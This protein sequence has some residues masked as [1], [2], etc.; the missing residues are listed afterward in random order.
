MPPKR[1]V[2]EF[3]QSRRARLQPDEV[4]VPSTGEG[5]RVPGLRRSELAQLAG[6]SVEYYTRLEQGRA[7]NVSAMVLDAI[8][9]ALRLDDTE[10][11]HL[12]DLVRPVPT[13]RPRRSPKQRVRP[14]VH[15]VLDSVT[16]PAFVLGRRMDVLAANRMARL[17]LADF[18]AMEPARRN[19][20]RWI[21]LEPEVR[22]LYVDW[23]T[24]AKETVAILRFD[25]GRHP[26]DPQLSDLVGELSMKAPEFAGWWAEHD[27]EDRTFGSKRYRHPTVG[28]LRIDYEAM[29]L[30]DDNDQLLLIYTTERGSRSEQALQLL[31]S[32]GAGA[33][34]H[35]DEVAGSGA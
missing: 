1:D 15:A 10:R 34:A 12:A 5:R 4:G 23:D 25:A 8:A 30:P 28:E 22:E 7:G 16:G 32:W 27:V 18:E 2:A 9:S 19:M 24:V 35:V 31:G 33:P 11:A 17:L 6:V 20:A 21:F 14:G 3:L 29:R 26:D 13:T